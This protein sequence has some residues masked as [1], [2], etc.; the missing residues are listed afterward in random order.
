M[1]HP[2]ATPT[3][4]DR[5]TTPLKLVRGQFQRRVPLFKPVNVGVIAE[6]AANKFGRTVPIYLD[7]PFSWDP[8]HRD[9]LDYVDYANLVER[10]SAAFKA[11]GAER[12]DR[13][14]IVKSRSYDIQ[15]FVWAAARIGAIPAPLS[16]G[17]DPAVLNVLLERL[18]PRI[19]ITDSETARYAG[20]DTDR[21]RAL[22]CVA[23]GIDQVEGAISI[24]E[25]WDA[26]T[27]A[28]SPLKDDEPMVIT[29]TSS[30][31]GVSKLVEASATGVSFTALMESIFPFGHSHDELLANSISHAHIAAT[32]EQLAAFSRG[33]PLLGIG[34]PD[35]ATILRLFAR[36]RPTIALAHPNDFMDWEA[37]V[38]DPAKPFASVR[39]FFNTFDAMH[40]RTIR[41]LLNASERKFPF[42]VDIYGMTETQALT[43]SFFT[44]RSLGRRGNPDS[45]GNGWPL[46]G[47]RVR[48]ADPMNGGR[49]RHQSEPGM[50]QAKTRA[51]ALS[52]VGTPEKY[53]QR[54]HGRWFDTGDWGRRGRWGQLKLLDR[55]ADRIDGVESCIA[56]ED[57]L[58]DRIP[59]AREVV[60]VPDGDGRPVPV[61]C[62]RDGTSLSSSTWRRVSADLPS[63]EYPFIIDWVEL[64]RTATAKARRFVLS[65]M[66][67]N[68]GS[69]DIGQISSTVALRDGA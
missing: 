7:E 5:R 10:L 65:E 44:R 57:I 45:R 63:L 43:A 54:R 31:T 14:A 35:E 60:I 64:E 2:R 42:W 18:Q 55:V 23:I 67:K 28:P 4:L 6:L 59:D 20:L 48:I 26:P 13:I 50:I 11:A 41:R 24:E 38:D 25:L 34:K 69:M 56:I 22:S 1:N 15:A 66:I 16:A 30:T 46:P 17:L 37:L 52:F 3:L 68:G 53:S 61:V 27:P 39:V 47:V 33:T 8:E 58:L 49:R 51:N 21:F 40:S 19:L 62:M 36:H 32:T 12:W 9:T 29:H